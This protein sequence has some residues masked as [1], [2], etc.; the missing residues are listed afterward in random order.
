MEAYGVLNQVSYI[1]P[2]LEAAIDFWTRT[3]RVGPFFVFPPF[4]TEKGDYRGRAMIPEFGAAIAY[5]GELMVELIEPR[6]PSIFQEHLERRSGAVHHLA[7]FAES[8][9][10]AEAAVAAQ[11]GR[12]LQGTSFAGGSE[13]AYFA[14]TPDESIILEIAVLAPA[15]HQLF[16]AIKAAG[17]AWDGARRTIS[18]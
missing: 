5:S 7:A 15:A 2:D 1:V 17:A 10:A 9:P 12:R 13:V 18:F 8:M 3:M 6:G 14:M 11:G 16:A 4:E